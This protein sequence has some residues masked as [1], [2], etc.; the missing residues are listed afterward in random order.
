[1]P[2][3]KRPFRPP[4]KFVKQEIRQEILQ[5]AKDLNLSSNAMD[6]LIDQLGG[7]KK[8]KRLVLDRTLAKRR[9][10]SYRQLLRTSWRL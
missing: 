8:A 9:L 7:L 6:D 5:E 1:M 4:K 2:T 10:S 3:C